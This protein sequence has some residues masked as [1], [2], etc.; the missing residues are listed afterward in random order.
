MPRPLSPEALAA[1]F[2]RHLERVTRRR[3]RRGLPA[4]QVRVEAPSFLYRWGDERMPFH[5][6]SIGKLATAALVAQDITVGRLDW[7]TR[8]E[9]VLASAETANLFAASGATVEQLLGHTSG[10]AD[11]FEGPTTDGPSMIRR[12]IDEP[13]H[14]W[15]AAQLIAFSREHQHPVGSPGERF[16]YS[17]TGFALLGRILETV[18]GRDYTTLLRERVLDPA[19]MADSALWL[20]EPGPERIAPIWLHRTEVSTF[21]SV[22]CG[23]AGGG[24]VATLDDIARLGAALTD[25][26]LVAPEAWARMTQPHH[27]F[28][29]G[30]R[31]GLGTMQ[32]HFEGFSPLLRGLPRPV[33]H[34]GSLATHLFVD[35]EHG[36]NVVLNFH[37]GREMV[38]S[39]QTH[40]R[41]AQGLAR[42]L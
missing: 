10:V 29:A 14:R 3:A 1:S 19:C 2:D 28:R 11:Y 15:D 30:I 41:I 21:A 23:W 34:L 13:D 25:G 37:G 7:T 26:T 33:G 39:F 17:D 8:V 20:R 27:R 6:A 16:A 35:P 32:L 9:D 38:A 40:I 22:S 5:A 36:T 12:V 24:I 31:Y 42:L 18:N 4:P